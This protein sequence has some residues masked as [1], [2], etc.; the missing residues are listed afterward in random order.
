[1]QVRT[2]NADDFCHYL[3]PD[4]FISLLMQKP[5]EA[6]VTEHVP[7]ALRWQ[8]L[9]AAYRMA[10]LATH[11]V[12]GFTIKLV[13]LAYFAFA[14]LF[15]FLRYA[16]LPNIDYYKGDIER[17]ASRALGNPVSIARIYASWHGVRPNLFLGDVT[18]RDQAGRQALSLPSISATVSWWSLLGSVRFTTLEITRPDLDVRRSKDGKL[19]V[20]G[21]LIDSTQGSDGKGADWLL[22]QHD[23]IIRDGKVRWTDEARGTPELALSQVNLLLRNRWRSH[24]L[25]LQATPPASLAAP[26]DVRAHFTHPPFSTR[27]SDVSMWKGELYADL[28]S[29]ATA[30]AATGWAC[31]PHCL[32]VWPHPS[33]CALTSRIRPSARASR[34]CRCG[35]ASCMRT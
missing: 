7:L 24:R 12:L 31:R 8:R 27:I 23:I 10:N 20:A 9:R 16:I 13:L 22:S 30:G 6:S 15:L 33:M 4:Q 19:Y 29:C 17:A 26:I 21:V 1:M 25:G 14:V 18:L 5:P 2:T 3:T 34:M 32:P 11:H 28:K 35:K